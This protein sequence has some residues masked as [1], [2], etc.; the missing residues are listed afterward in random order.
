MHISKLFQKYA[1]TL[2]PP[3]K[4]VEEECVKA[5]QKFCHLDITPQSVLYVPATRT[6]TLHTPALLRTEI[7]RKEERII[8]LLREILGPDNAP[9]RIS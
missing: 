7:K 4:H 2:R 5:I 3:Q 9:K 8:G 1:L 6:I